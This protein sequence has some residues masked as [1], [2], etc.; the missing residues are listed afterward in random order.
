MIAKDFLHDFLLYKYVISTGYVC[1][2]IEKNT[3][4]KKQNNK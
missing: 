1:I 2:I 4:R 3:N